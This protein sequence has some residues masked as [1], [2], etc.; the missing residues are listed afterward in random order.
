[1]MDVRI[2]ITA[3][4]SILECECLFF[5]FVELSRILASDEELINPWLTSKIGGTNNAGG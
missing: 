4:Y 5:C 1:M 2:E 3:L